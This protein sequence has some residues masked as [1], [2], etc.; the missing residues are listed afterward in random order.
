MLF[1]FYSKIEV[2]RGKWQYYGDKRDFK[3]FG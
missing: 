3:A 2:D 1:I